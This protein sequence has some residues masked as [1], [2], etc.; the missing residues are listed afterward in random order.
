LHDLGKEAGQVIA[1]QGS[2]AEKQ[3]G[4]RHVLF[5]DGIELSWVAGAYIELVLLDGAERL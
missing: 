1:G 2:G 5:R 3:D 4:G